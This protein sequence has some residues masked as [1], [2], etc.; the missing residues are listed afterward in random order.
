MS[1]AAVSADNNVRA[2]KVHLSDVI[3]DLGKKSRIRART[4]NNLASRRALR[5]VI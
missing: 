5:F 2:Y 1:S 4:K 3:S